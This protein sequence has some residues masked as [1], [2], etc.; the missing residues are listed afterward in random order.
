MRSLQID[1]QKGSGTDAGPFLLP[2]PCLCPD[3]PNNSC[4][5]TIRGAEAQFAAPEKKKAPGA[6]TRSP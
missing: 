6:W 2:A 1:A 4:A 3:L 5:P